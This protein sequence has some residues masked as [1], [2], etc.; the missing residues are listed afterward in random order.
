MR[1]NNKWTLSYLLVSGLVPTEVLMIL[2]NC[3][4]TKM[5]PLLTLEFSELSVCDTV[6]HDM[7]F[8]FFNTIV[9]TKT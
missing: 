4:I 2:V 7:N 3:E 1:T 5:F 6:P 9:H 8:M